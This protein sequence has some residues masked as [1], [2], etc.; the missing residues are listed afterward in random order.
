MGLF[1]PLGRNGPLLPAEL[2]D[3]ADVERRRHDHLGSQVDEPL[4]EL[5]RRVALEES[6]VDVG[7]GDVDHLLRVLD[8]ADAHE[9]R[10]GEL[11]R[12]AE[13]PGEAGAIE[14]GEVHGLRMLR[15]SST[16]GSSWAARPC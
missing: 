16:R 5:E 10:H 6:A 4:G 7:A 11:R 12:L 1:R 15:G 8:L 9:D 2:V 13:V 14:F 3:A